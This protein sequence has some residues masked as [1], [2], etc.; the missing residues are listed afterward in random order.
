MFQQGP[1]LILR[2]TSLTIIVYPSGFPM[3]HQTLVSCY[4]RVSYI[5]FNVG[6]LGGSPFPL[7]D[8]KADFEIKLMVIKG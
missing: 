4:E 2:H 1:H 5:N 3:I 8:G 7:S 6:N